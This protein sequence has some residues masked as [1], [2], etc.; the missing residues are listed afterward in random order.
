[1]PDNHREAGGSGGLRRRGGE[2]SVFSL[3]P[4]LESENDR[5]WGQLCRRFHAWSCMVGLTAYVGLYEIGR[6][7]KGETVFV[8][9]AFGAVGQL[10]GQFA[11]LVGCHVVGSAGSK[12]KPHLVGLPQGVREPFPWLPLLLLFPSPPPCG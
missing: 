7:K 4:I 2:E 8:S 5:L 11:K 12:E 9:S 6:P 3:R 10:V 1:M